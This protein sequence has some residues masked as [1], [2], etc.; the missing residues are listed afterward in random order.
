MV[1]TA[2]IVHKEKD[3]RILINRHTDYDPDKDPYYVGFVFG[4]WDFISPARDSAYKSWYK[5]ELFDK[6]VKV[7]DFPFEGSKGLIDEIINE[8]GESVWCNGEI[9]SDS[10]CDTSIEDAFNSLDR[11]L[12]CT[13]CIGKL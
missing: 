2:L 4:G 9:M 8:Y 1:A 12:F 13:L 3:P 10:P 11:E 5:E 7:K 6:T